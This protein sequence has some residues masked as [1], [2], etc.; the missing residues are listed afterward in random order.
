MQKNQQSINH[1]KMPQKVPLYLAH[2]EKSTTTYIYMYIHSCII[3]AYPLRARMCA[4]RSRTCDR[5]P[6]ARAARV[7]QQLYASLPKSPVG[8]RDRGNVRIS[9]Q[10]CLFFLLLHLLK[11]CTA[12]S[13]DS[14]LSSKG[15]E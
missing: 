6:T 5:S 12:R 4:F 14:S 1:Q 11:V 15:D 9:M 3:I 10:N 13:T 7:L 2:I 8:L